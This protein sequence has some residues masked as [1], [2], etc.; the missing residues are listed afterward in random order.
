MEFVNTQ[1]E[2]NKQLMKD[3]R[4]SVYFSEKNQSAK[5]KLI[6]KVD[7]HCYLDRFSNCLVNLRS[8]GSEK[9]SVEDREAKLKFK[10]NIYDY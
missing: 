7:C 6:R 4:K 1:T 3:E 8:V 10:K 9:L 2:M 5:T